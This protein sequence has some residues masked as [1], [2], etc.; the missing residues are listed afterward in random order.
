MQDALKELRSGGIPA[1]GRICNL[2]IK[3]G[4]DDHHVTWHIPRSYEKASG[5]FRSNK[6][7]FSMKF[8]S[9]HHLFVHELKDLYSAENQILKALPRMA[10]A[11]TNIELKRAFLNHLDETR[12]HIR[13]LEEIF[14]NLEFRASD[15]HGEGA[16]GLITEGVQFLEAEADC[17]VRDAGLIFCAQ[18]VEHYEIAGYGGAIALAEALGTR[19]ALENLRLTLAEE[20]AADR[21]LSHLSEIVILAGALPAS[22]N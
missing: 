11:A 21:N 9:L 10:E 16:E 19:R 6:T 1:P 12:N 7:T 20:D 15:S 5:E 8:D 2:L 3:G 18:R 22:A 14:G 13:R 4:L 17:R